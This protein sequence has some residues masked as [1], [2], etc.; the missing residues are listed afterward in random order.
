MIFRWP[1]GRYQGE[2]TVVDFTG[3]MGA[4]IISAAIFFDLNLIGKKVTGDM[5][6][7]DLP[8]HMATP[9][10][11]GEC[12]HWGWQLDFL[13]HS[14]SS[15]DI[16]HGMQA[17]RPCVIRDGA[18]KLELGLQALAKPEVRERFALSSHLFS[19]LPIDTSQKY[20][21]IHIRR[22]DYLNV[23]SHLVPTQY[24]MSI[25]RKFSKLI[26]KVVVISDSP[27]ESLLLETLSQSFGNVEILDTI[28]AQTA[29]IIMRSARVLIGSNSQFSLVAAALST[30]SLSLVPLRWYGDSNRDLEVL[31]S[32]RC[33]FQIFN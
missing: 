33:S 10:N 2:V 30:D 15:F 25:T 11:V 12:S 27:V 26:E 13:G 28:D 6:Y 14:L 1:R 29:H 3:G 31:L 4:Q 16:Q 19:G 5:T 9:G 23:A 20:L 32:D 7:F 17:S 22:G 18:Q 24:F 21:C 8:Q